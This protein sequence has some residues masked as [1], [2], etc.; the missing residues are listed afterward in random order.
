MGS[1]KALAI[2][3]LAF[4]LC[5]CS[6][7]KGGNSQLQTYIVHVH[8]PE[9]T[10]FASDGDRK[11]WY[12]SFLPTTSASGD[13][14]SRMIYSYENLASGFA[15]RLTKE[16]VKDMEKKDGFISANPDRLLQLLTT[17]TPSFLGLQPQPKAW[18]RKNHGE[19]VVIGV[20]DTG[21]VPSHPSFSGEGMAP[22]PAKWK[23]RCEFQAS[24]CNN[25]LIGARAFLSGAM[26]MEGAGA[27]PMSPL[28]DNGHG[29]HIAGTAAGAA[30]KNASV[31]GQAGGTAVGMAPK[32]HLAIY[33]VCTGKG[34]AVSDVLAGYDTAVADGV[35]VISISL[36]HHGVP[37]FQD[38]VAVGT[39][40]AMEK[41][42]FVSCAAGNDGPGSSTLSNDAPWMLTVGAST[43][44]RNIRAT[45][46]LG[47]GTAPIVGESLYQ[48]K[49]FPSTPLP[50]VD[51]GAG[52]E[53]GAAFCGNGSLNGLDVKGKV[54]LCERGAGIIQVAKGEVVKAAGGAAMILMNDKPSEF[55]TLVEAHVL[56][57][58]HVTYAD[59]LKIR[60][61]I[62]SSSKPTAT[63]LFQGTIVGT[64]PAPAMASFSSRGPS[65]VSRG[66]LKPDITGPGVSI[67][68]AWASAIGPPS[69]AGSTGPFFNVKSGTSMSTPHLSGIVALIKRKHP[70]WSPAAIKSAI[71]TT[72]SVFSQSRKRIVDET[73]LPAD[74]FAMGAGHVNP[75]RAVDPG[76]VYDLHANDYISYL[77]GLN[78]T[79]KQVGLVVGR[80]TDCSKAGSIAGKDLNY[81]S[82]SVSLGTKG[83]NV[84]V[85]RT[86]RN[87][88][89]AANSV[90]R[91]KVEVPKHVSVCVEPKMLAFHRLNQELS[92]TVTI[93]SGPQESG[94]AEGQLSWVGGGHYVVRSPISI[95]HE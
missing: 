15:A 61:Y 85:K 46:K 77:C 29:T 94:V 54:V 71:M 5:L 28:D 37:F 59:G 31:L 68:A 3:F 52:G 84:T 91:A 72:A 42:V 12:R 88:G 16:E 70:D 62:A 80:P 26:A 66:I 58:S 8:P 57:A 64:S 73:L 22:P 27:V 11:S 21:V 74:F 90:Y 51:A 63:I 75:V 55:S 40:R 7:A 60:A 45:V 23:G 87:V 14:G 78:Y 18:V 83:G 69:A 9:S 76:L 19:G 89:L 10:V 92:F 6:V 38:E 35:D 44:D 30:V 47:N 43:I 20:L 1:H 32:A 41:G 67:I 86:V 33:K 93:S 24:E 79:S 2:S 65:T 36:G 34:C 53:S 49:D 56:P 17:R 50:L 4:L 82:I 39:F 81:P 48:P 95:T 13:D 25:K